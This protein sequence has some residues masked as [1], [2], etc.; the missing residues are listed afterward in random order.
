M[1]TIRTSRNKENIRSHLIEKQFKESDFG[2]QLFRKA[3]NT[4][5]KNAKTKALL[6]EEVLLKR[7]Y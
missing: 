2:W 7:Y 3:L 4:N 5:I 1:H 6:P